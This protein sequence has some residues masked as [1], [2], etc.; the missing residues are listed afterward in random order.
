MKTRVY[1]W[2]V[3]LFLKP[4]KPSKPS[5][6][7]MWQRPLAGFVGRFFG[8]LAGFSSGTVQRF[9]QC[10]QWIKCGVGRFGRFYRQE[11]VSSA[12]KRAR[13]KKGSVFQDQ[14]R[15]LASLKTVQTVQTVHRPEGDEQMMTVYRDDLAEARALVR[16]LERV[17]LFFWSVTNIS[18]L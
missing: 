4:S 14:S 9:S 17:A 13:R 15:K 2:E 12:H 8:D 7:R 3:S 10:F 16:D 6:G 1:A 11:T 5:N 18:F